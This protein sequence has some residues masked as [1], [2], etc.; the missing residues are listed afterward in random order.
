MQRLYGNGVHTGMHKIIYLFPFLLFATGSSGQ[1][2]QAV[3]AELGKNGIII[4]AGYD[5]QF[6]NNH[7]GFRVGAG[8]NFD[9]YLKAY[10]FTAGVYKLA[11]RKFHFF[12]AGL[13]LQYLNIQE[14]SDDQRG[15]GFIYP[16]Y[17]V[18][19]F[20]PSVNFG[21]RFTGK[22]ILFRTGFSP[23]FIKRDFVPGVYLSLGFGW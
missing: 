13:D 10:V 22:T 2:R 11:G 17:T 6:T 16:D 7:T 8:T 4:H 20:Y 21:Y 14:N 5:R 19:A 3:Y 9:R 18:S 15:F 1:S 23:G 12:E